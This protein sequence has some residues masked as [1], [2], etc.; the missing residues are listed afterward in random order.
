MQYLGTKGSN[1]WLY[2]KILAA[3]PTKLQT[4]H[5]IVCPALVYWIPQTNS[6]YKSVIKRILN[7]QQIKCNIVRDHEA[8]C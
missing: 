4:S 7:T 3:E 5:E 2:I 6:G 8:E 1:S